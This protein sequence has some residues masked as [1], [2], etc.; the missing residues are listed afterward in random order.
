MFVRRFVGARFVGF[1]IVVAVSGVQ[2]VDVDSE[3]LRLCLLFGVGFGLFHDLF[4][5]FCFRRHSVGLL[6]FGTFGFDAVSMLNLF[7]SL[8]P[9]FIGLLLF[10]VV[11]C[12]FLV[13][14]CE[15]CSYGYV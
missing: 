13:P 1:V 8:S 3:W 14:A 7:Y 10:I 15:F 11:L 2:V 12:L 4:H 6:T 9:A 5:T